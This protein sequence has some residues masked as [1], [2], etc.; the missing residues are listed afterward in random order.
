MI[1]DTSN[2]WYNQEISQGIDNI[3]LSTNILEHYDNV[4]YNL[5]LYMFPFDEQLNIEKEIFNEGNKINLN[6]NTE[7]YKK[8]IIAES[9][10]TSKFSINSVRIKNYFGSNSKETTIMSYDV[11]IKLFESYGCNF[12]NELSYVSKVI[13]YQSYF[14]RPVWLDIWFSGYDPED[15]KPVEKIPLPN[16]NDVITLRGYLGTVKNNITNLGTEWDIELIPIYKSLVNDKYNCLSVNSIIK[17][18]TGIKLDEFMKNHVRNIYNKMLD[19]F[20]LPTREKREEIIGSEYGNNPDNYI[21]INYYEVDKDSDNIR[22]MNDQNEKIINLSEMPILEKNIGTA[23]D[24]NGSSSYKTDMS[25]TFTSVCQD[26]LHHSIRH[27][28]YTA[29]YYVRSRILKYI[30]KRPIY[31]HEVDII[32][33]KNDLI[34]YH[35]NQYQDVNFYKEVIKRNGKKTDEEIEKIR[36]DLFNKYLGN[37]TLL[38]KY[39]FAFSGED[40]SVIEMKTK[41]ED[42]YF[43]P[44]TTYEK[45]LNSNSVTKYT[46]DVNNY[47]YDSGYVEEVFS[48]NELNNDAYLDDFYFNNKDKNLDG[49]FHGII[50]MNDIDSSEE[51]KN[52]SSAYT[53]T[54]KEIIDAKILYKRFF[55]SASISTMKLDIYGD[56]YW[57]AMN[58]QNI[59]EN[60]IF[61]EDNSGRKI[62]DFNIIPNIYMLRNNFRFIFILKT[63]P[64][65][66]S[67]IDTPFDYSFENSIYVSGIYMATECESNFE[68]G[69]FTQSLTGTL[70][71]SLIKDDIMY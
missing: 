56:P 19:T 20:P 17:N 23:V 62:D 49:Y 63:C 68:N 53:S 40:T 42:L 60:E 24:E 39:Q 34:E 22:H 48:S 21:K 38:K 55:K 71:T 69:K 14:Q 59:N 27:K 16:G 32:L 45:E 52:A 66:T 13:G 37:H 29:K 41:I 12:A 54:D 31:Q 50:K 9:G 36:L 46:E 57:L 7:K 18:N 10:V 15:G 44:A 28:T 51:L 61:N 6:I 26:F 1:N 64:E 11:N 58:A 35:L 47:T 30:L 25:M 67:G 70:D 43:L 33:E 3:P 8:I 65:Q 4:T 2:K 5:R